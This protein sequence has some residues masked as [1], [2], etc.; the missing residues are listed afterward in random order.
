MKDI[1][2]RYK[3]KIFYIAAALVLI[4]IL[5]F[6]V[7]KPFIK[8][9]I[10]EKKFLEAGKRYYEINSS[11]LPIGT[12]IG[13]VSL[14]TIYDKDFIEED[15]RLSKYSKLCDQDASWVKVQKQDGELK[16]SV[17]LKCGMFSS[18]TDHTGPIISL[19]G[20]EIIILNKG[21]KYKELGVS[22]VVD[23]HDGNIDTK[24]VVIDASK[25]NTNKVGTYQI[26]YKIKDSY[27]NETI[28]Y[29]T[30]IVKQLLDQ[31]VKNDTNS[32]NIYKGNNNNN[33]ILIDNILFRIMGLNNDNTVKLITDREISFVDYNSI[34]EWIEEEFYSKLSDSAKEIIVDKKY[35]NDV[36]TD[37]SAYTKCKSYT[38]SR[39]VYLPSI[40]DIN[41]SKD[42]D[43]VHNV[44]S[45][46]YIWL[47][48]KNENKKAWRYYEGYDIADT[49]DMGAVKLVIIVKADLNIKSGVGTEI[50][51][52]ILKEN[53][54]RL[55]VGD[56]ISKATTGSYISYSGYKW[57]V[58]N[59]E[60]DGTTKIILNG[61][62][63]SNQEV[64][65][66]EI[67]GVNKYNP[68]AKNNIGY[69]V[70][71]NA[72]KFVK[73][74]YFVNSDNI[75]HYHKNNLNYKESTAKKY[76]SLLSIPSAFDIYS[77]SI[78]EGFWVYDNYDDYNCYKKYAGALECYN[79]K[80][81]YAKYV[82]VIA[83]LA[84]GVKVKSGNGKSTNPYV[85]V[86]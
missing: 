4:V 47:G 11:K 77:A 30:V 35:C 49:S 32:D 52:Y 74:N 21:D 59:S 40:I 3:N 51:P 25:L 20:Q 8:F 76:K 10:M 17:Y 82:R 7:I 63:S 6:V 9:K 29:R 45:Q 23:D 39:K 18:K 13:T 69:K 75:Y 72:R 16:Y 27:N 12:N 50:N 56:K 64:Y 81:S 15:L 78:N 70:N 86:K 22:S 46:M 73:T 19:K 67:V 60:E 42:A 71:I 58:M 48:N 33:Y 44:F 36:V 31:T 24:K 54:T 84:S 85:I 79:D 5:F 53:N 80:A 34:D 28:K 37:P 14:K 83:H 2:N 66:E 61:V 57:R 68:N 65:D 26:A 41:E 1:Y 43:G 38:K 55:K 62:L